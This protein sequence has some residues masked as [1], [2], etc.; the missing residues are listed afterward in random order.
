MCTHKKSIFLTLCGVA[1]NVKYDVSDII[2][3]QSLTFI[4]FS[5]NAFS[6]SETNF[7]QPRLISEIFRRYKP[8][9]SFRRHSD[10]IWRPCQKYRKNFSVCLII[11]YT[12]YGIT[13]SKFHYS[14]KDTA[15][16]QNASVLTYITSFMTLWRQEWMN[17]DQVGFLRRDRA[18]PF[19]VFFIFPDSTIGSRDTREGG[20]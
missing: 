6:H 2:W 11:L 4:V 8:K 1:H 17:Q 20:P 13:F 3:R 9:K 7:A 12:K 5:V 15:C 10:V 18:Q 19:S 16:G 14:L